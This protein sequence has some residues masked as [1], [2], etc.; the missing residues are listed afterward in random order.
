ML[1]DQCN[2]GIAV[3]TPGGLLVPVVHRADQLSLLEIARETE[4]LSSEARAGKSKL[5]DLRSGTFTVT[6]IGSLGG[7]FSTPIILPPQVAIL[8]MGKI[9]KRPGLRRARSAAAPPISFICR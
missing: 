4:R 3:A 6:S 8:G 9:V 7:L 5:E 2:I 1:H